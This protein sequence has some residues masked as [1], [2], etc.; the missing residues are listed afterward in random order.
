MA[1][2]REDWNDLLAAVNEVL[3]NP[4]EDTDCSDTVISPLSMVEENHRWS[5][6]D[7]AAVH[8]KLGQTTCSEISFSAIPDKW[9]QSVIDEINTAIGQA[10]CD[11]EEQTDCNLSAFGTICSFKSE[12]EAAPWYL[13]ED[14]ADLKRWHVRYHAIGEV[15]LVEL[16]DE[17]GQRS[18]IF[19][20]FP[21]TQGFVTTGGLSQSPSHE[22]IIF[23]S[24]APGQQ[25]FNALVEMIEAPCAVVGEP[26]ISNFPGSYSL[27][28]YKRCFPIPGG[29]EECVEEEL[30][31]GIRAYRPKVAT[32]FDAAGCPLS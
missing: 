2:K 18:G 29:G 6:A 28:E 17:N 23:G 8:A 1:Y 31:G 22:L 13:T 4:P 24:L 11:C 25:F 19:S 15:G 30:G 16:P 32:A 14:E 5:K 7:I 27:T 21:G 26:W 10:W 9:S 3:E 20:G 12:A